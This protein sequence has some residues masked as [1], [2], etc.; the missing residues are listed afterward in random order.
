MESN[1]SVIMGGSI[2]G[3]LTAK[4][5]SP[6]F[7][8]IIILDRDQLFSNQQPRKGTAQAAHAHILL[9]RGLVGLDKLLPGFSQKVK[10]VGAVSTNATYDW[11]SLFPEG[12]LCR[13]KSDMELLCQSRHLLE[14]T[15]REFVI[16]NTPNL[17]IV[18][19]A[20]VT[21]VDLYADQR[22]EIQYTLNDENIHL[23]ADL[24]VDCTGRNTKSPLHLKNA[25]F[26]DVP[27]KT[28]S[29]YLGYAT[30]TYKN[31]TLKDNYR[32]AL[33]M[34]KDPNNTRGGIILPIEENQYIV[35]LFGFSKD[36]PPGNESAFLAFANS[37]RADTV[38][39]AIKNAE[40]SS[41]IK[42]F[43]K[44]D[45]HFHQYSKLK[46]WPQGFLAIGDSITS[47]NPIYGQGITTT[48]TSAE[49]LQKELL[50]Y[51]SLEMFD[52]KSLQ[53]KICQNYNLPW[54]IAKNEDLRW[55]GTEG[56]KANG[57]LK[58]MHGFSD[59]VARA[60]TKDE[61]VNYTY[62]SILHM[63]KLP[64]ALLTPF[65]LYK[66]IKHGRKETVSD[67]TGQSSRSEPN[68]Q[69]NESNPKNTDPL[70]PD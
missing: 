27:K 49:I 50:Q 65:M 29:P 61:S 54:M 67:Q 47:F 19:N 51:T 46:K 44:K 16:E 68:N 40:P 34:A 21:H 69:A 63:M 4:V 59:M 5:L 7:S 33:I 24:L 25:G 70:Q 55:P 18:E 10:S 22:P 35:T 45:S 9:K 39:N 32:S 31:I 53:R 60:S 1:V 8:K 12:Y 38:F 62:V 23:H 43:V 66:I 2:A 20:S 28:I 41:E 30:R 42:Q 14:S 36:Y 58:K 3:L 64:T 13:F 6:Y 26:G 52:L 15:L 37:L 48:I 57:L 17:E 56:E 11:Q